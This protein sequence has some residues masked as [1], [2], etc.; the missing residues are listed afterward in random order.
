MF[1]V[2]KEKERKERFPFVLQGNHIVILSE[3][4]CQKNQN[5]LRLTGCE[6]HRRGWRGSTRLLQEM[7][8]KIWEGGVSQKKG[9]RP[10]GKQTDPLSLKG[11][12]DLNCNF[13]GSTKSGSHS[14]EVVFPRTVC[15]RLAVLENQVSER[16]EETH[17]FV[18]AV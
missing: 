9:P 5:H 12:A 13:M 2:H 18:S 10:L 1:P 6:S 3:G 16:G 4:V 17:A 11:A 8:L 7:Q 14:E 15:H